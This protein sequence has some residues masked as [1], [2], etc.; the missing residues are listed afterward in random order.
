MFYFLLEIGLCFCESF[1]TLSS[2]VIFYFI[3]NDLFI[4]L[5][6]YLFIYL[7]MYLFIY[8]FTYLFIYL[9]IIVFISA[10]LF[11]RYIRQRRRFRIIAFF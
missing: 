1:S 10:L 7:F 2:I 4:C 9:L 6:I 8:L 5:F 3:L 11:R